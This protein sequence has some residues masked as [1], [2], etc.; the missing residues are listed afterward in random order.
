LNAL[1][2]VALLLYLIPASDWAVLQSIGGGSGSP[3]LSR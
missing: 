1:F 3:P 2:L